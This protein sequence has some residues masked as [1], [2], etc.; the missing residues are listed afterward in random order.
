[1]IASATRGGEE[2]ADPPR[3][4]PVGQEGRGPAVCAERRLSPAW[5]GLPGAIA[6][7]L[8]DVARVKLQA[9]IGAVALGNRAKRCERAVSQSASATY[10]VSRYSS[11]PSK[12]P[13]RPKPLALTPPNGAAGLD[14]SPV[15]TPIMPKSSASAS[16]IVRWRSRV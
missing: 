1:M 15:L 12:P 14:T 4:R 11:I 7:I 9:H 13:S 5:T 8:D 2:P 10:V 6:L 16:R 3:R